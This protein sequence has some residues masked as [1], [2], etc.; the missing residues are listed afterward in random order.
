MKSRSLIQFGVSFL[1]SFCLLAWMFQSVDWR[2]IGKVVEKINCLYVLPLILLLSFQLWLRTIRWSYLLGGKRLDVEPILFD[3]MMIGNLATYVLPR[4]AG[5]FLRP[6]VASSASS[7][8][9]P[10]CFLSVVMERFFDLGVVLLFFGLVAL[11]VP[12][13]DGWVYQGALLLSL[14]AG[15]ICG[16]ILI[17]VIFP[18]LIINFVRSMV[19]LLKYLPQSP[20]VQKMQS[21]LKEGAEVFLQG[22]ANLKD[23]Y[24]LMMVLALSVLIWLSTFA[25]YQVFLYAFNFSLSTSWWFG[26]TITVIVALAVAAPSAPGFIGVYQTACFAAFALFEMNKEIALAYGIIS[27]VFQYLSIVLLGIWSISRRGMKFRQLIHLAA[28]QKG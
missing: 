15:I 13:L 17:G 5:E 1:I 22:T 6:F 7:F 8:S 18:T 21:L 10:V 16:I 28:R 14:I 3:A 23:S 27:H 19:K 20:V 25:F 4:R 26:I 24:T 12:A 2:E 9:F 11:R